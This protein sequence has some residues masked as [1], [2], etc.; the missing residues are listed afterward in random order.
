MT[1]GSGAQIVNF[2]SYTLTVTDSN[3]CTSTSG[4]I[5]VG[6]YAVLNQGIGLGCN[7]PLTTTVTGG[8]GSY[9][10]QLVKNNVLQ[11]PTN[12]TGVF[13]ITGSVTA[14]YFAIVTDNNTTCVNDTQT[15]NYAGTPVG[16]TL[17]VDSQVSGCS[18][19]Q[20]TATGGAPFSGTPNY[21]TYTLIGNITGSYSGS[22]DVST[23]YTSP[24]VAPGIYTFTATDVN[25]CTGSSMVTVGPYPTLTQGTP[26]GGLLPFTINVTGGTATFT[27]SIL[28]NDVVM[29]P[30][31]TITSNMFS[32]DSTVSGSYTIVATDSKGCAGT[33]LPSAYSPMSVTFTYVQTCSNV[34]FTPTITGGTPFPGNVASANKPYFA[35]IFTVSGSNNTSG[36][37]IFIPTLPEPLS[38]SG[39]GTYVVTFTDSAGNH[40]SFTYVN[41]RYLSYVFGVGTDCNIPVILTV[42][43][44]LSPYSYTVINAGI[45]T[46]YATGTIGADSS[47]DDEGTFYINGQS[48]QAYY[49][50]ITDANNCSNDNSLFIPAPTPLTASLST[51]SSGCPATVTVTVAGGLQ[52]DDNFSYSLINTVTST[53]V[54]S[55]S[56]VMN[57]SFNLPQTVPAGSYKIQITNSLGCTVVSNTL[58]IGFVATITRDT[59]YCS[60]ATFT[61]NPTGGSGLYI[62]I[63]YLNGNLYSSSLLVGTSTYSFTTTTTGSYTV[64][65]T[66]IN[67][68]CVYTTPAVFFTQFSVTVTTT[69]NSDC[70][71]TLVAT[72][73]GTNPLYTYQIV[74]TDPNSHGNVIILVISFATTVYSQFQLGSTHRS[75]YGY[76]L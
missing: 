48:T 75:V 37:G 44:G 57:P 54:Q 42:H 25:G 45:N 38:E 22:I 73:Y 50:S 19:V 8:S 64:Q 2:G 18:K 76:R 20:A 55:G 41:L 49:V 40:A 33:S 34:S 1:S 39:Y 12:T 69:Y 72:V 7:V 6:F 66:D 46:V 58:I 56:A 61:T 28:D 17:T 21:Y 3:G 52:T 24:A 4:P 27:Y 9:T 13:S 32:V 71:E 30:Q 16:T 62:F 31:P 5:L 11:T 59:L 10:Y 43:G 36:S 23:T 67:T 51:V 29:S 60:T 70:S 63:A 53:V 15:I 68:G 65:V 14:S 26:S 47:S 35:Y 74:V